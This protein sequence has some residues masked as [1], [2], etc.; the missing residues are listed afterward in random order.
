MGRFGHCATCAAFERKDAA[1]GECRRQ[2]PMPVPE[3]K[4]CSGEQ[5][6]L[7]GWPSVIDSEGCMDHVPDNEG[8][9]LA[10]L[11][12]RY[13]VDPDARPT[14]PRPLRGFKVTPD[15]LMGG[16]P[17]HKALRAWAKGDA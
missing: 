9:Q 17:L 15:K 6:W 14:Q 10:D 8:E 12:R 4:T 16:M 7:T 3:F 11:L 2:S 13:D 1:L 5:R